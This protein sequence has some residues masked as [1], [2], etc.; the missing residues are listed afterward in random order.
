[1]QTGRSVTRNTERHLENT[2]LLAQYATGRAAADALRSA[3]S[4]ANG[5][6][7]MLEAARR[8]GVGALDELL[9]R[10]RPL[11]Q[12][13]VSRSSPRDE[14]E[15]EEL[16]AAGMT[17]LLRGIEK[18]D[19]DHGTTLGTYA[20]WWIRQAIGRER[21]RAGTRDLSSSGTYPFEHTASGDE[22]WAL[23]SDPSAEDRTFEIHNR[24]LVDG[25]RQRI[26]NL[27]PEERAT[28]VA[29]ISHG[30][31]MG[32]AAS[33]SEMSFGAWRLLFGTSWS[34]LQHPA[35]GA[36]D[37]T[38]PA[39]GEWMLKSACIDQPVTVFFPRRKSEQARAARICAKCPVRV[40]CL[41][42][43]VPHAH[44]LGIWGGCTEKERR[45]LRKDS[46][47]DMASNDMGSNDMA[48]ND[49]GS[50]AATTSGPV[51]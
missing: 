27:Q 11:V 51:P 47:H 25:M 50:V 37:D 2:D 12:Y 22:I 17:G 29:W 45:A 35:N 20:T 3:R 38:A 41:N 44:L 30:G 13:W 40:E 23:A 6:L 8:R 19:A 10:N 39:Y 28:I 36:L 43:A 4:L 34:K 33:A 15:R 14:H 9:R 1:M 31:H 32:R 42:V 48:S 18:Y 16:F 49:V 26:V 46:P 7:D 21:Q 5:E 24:A